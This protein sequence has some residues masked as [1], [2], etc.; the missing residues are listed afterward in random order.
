MSHLPALRSSGWLLQ[1]L[2]RALLPPLQ[3]RGRTRHD[4]APDHA[5]WRRLDIVLGADAPAHVLVLADVSPD[6]V[7]GEAVMADNG[8]TVLAKLEICRNSDGLVRDCGHEWKFFGDYIW[9]D[10]NYA[11]DCNRA[12]FFARAAGEADP[13]QACG[14]DVYS[15]RLTATDN[16]REL[17]S[18]GEWNS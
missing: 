18:D 2:W 14:G 16:G 12:L 13:N 1:G 3:Y 10:G 15:V 17:Y 6:R 5:R 11:C 7:S 4:L 8:E 9:C